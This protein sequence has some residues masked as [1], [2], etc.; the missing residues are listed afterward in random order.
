MEKTR[1]ERPIYG[2]FG[3]C[4]V[5][6]SCFQYVFVL[7]FGFVLL[8]IHENDRKNRRITQVLDGLTFEWRG[9]RTLL[10]VKLQGKKT[11]WATMGKEKDGTVH[12]LLL[13]PTT[14]NVVASNRQIGE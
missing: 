4:L 6:F 9:K 1:H 5:K 3:F 11:M 13:S 14:N 8:V 2:L 10:C 12:S 7:S